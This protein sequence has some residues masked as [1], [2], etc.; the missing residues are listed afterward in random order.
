MTAL[1]VFCYYQ[2]LLPNKLFRT[3]CTL[4]FSDAY[5]LET[6][7]LTEIKH[8]NTLGFVIYSHIFSFLVLKKWMVPNYKLKQCMTAISFT[9]DINCT[10]Y[11]FQN[12]KK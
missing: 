11:N 5:E 10:E 7:S 12:H 2:T 4:S 1:G 8:M 9:R 3:H 6:C